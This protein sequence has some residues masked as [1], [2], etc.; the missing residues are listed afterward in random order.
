[1]R[2]LNVRHKPTPASLDEPQEFSLGAS[3]GRA[4]LLG[5]GIACRPTP[6]HRTHRSNDPA[7]VG[8]GK[9]GETRPRHAGR[10]ME[11]SGH[12]VHCIV[13]RDMQGQQGVD[14]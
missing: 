9:D 5:K 10:P 12:R 3:Q 4:C 7:A 11:C 14:G 6:L 8:F 1:M 2:G 13:V